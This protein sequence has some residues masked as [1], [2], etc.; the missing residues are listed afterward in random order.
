[1]QEPR[2]RCVRVAHSPISLRFDL[3]VAEPSDDLLDLVPEL[4]PEA[5]QHT[6][7]RHRYQYEYKGIGRL[8]AVADLPS[9][10][11]HREERCLKVSLA[12]NLA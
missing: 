4:I 5:P 2:L 6:Y 7:H 12:E 11:G 1:M 3:D 10:E 8:T 9:A